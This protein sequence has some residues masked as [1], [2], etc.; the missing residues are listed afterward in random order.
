[1]S[2]K[3]SEVLFIFHFLFLFVFFLANT[4]NLS[5]TEAEKLSQFTPKDL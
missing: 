1:M 4:E 3:I 5:D 2:V